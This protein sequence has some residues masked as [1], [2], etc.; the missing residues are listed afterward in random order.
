MIAV[1]RSTNTD[2]LLDWWSERLK[3]GSVVEPDRGY[4]GD[5]RWMD[6]FPCLVPS[7]Y[8]LRDPGYNVANW[9]LHYRNLT[10]EGDRYYVNGEPLQSF[11]FSHFDPDRPDLFSMY[12]DRIR[13]HRG[14]ALARICEEYADALIAHGY[15]EAKNW[16]YTYGTLPNGLELDRFMRRLYRAG[17][18]S[19][20]LEGSIFSPKGAERFATW[21]EEP[22]PVGGKHGI[23]RYLSVRVIHRAAQVVAAVPEP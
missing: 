8:I 15:H 18:E 22:A 14:S 13:P 7:C 1:G 11:H 17:L 4:F 16:P 3:T 9:N 21:L 5:Q 10:I 20:E 23:T 6:L 12:Q 2:G 19:G